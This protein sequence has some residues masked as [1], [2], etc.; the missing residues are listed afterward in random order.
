MATRKFNCVLHFSATRFFSEL[1][2]RSSALTSLL[3]K[4]EAAFVSYV[5]W[6][7]VWGKS[8]SL[9]ALAVGIE[10][11]PDVSL[12]NKGNLGSPSKIFI[13]TTSYQNI[14]G[15]GLSSPVA[16]L[17]ISTVGCSVGDSFLKSINGC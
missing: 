15:L 1:F 6:R 17:C 9:S 8:L 16:D 4:V 5:V 2:P 3:L 12:T 13:C 7:L 11:K 14:P 10:I